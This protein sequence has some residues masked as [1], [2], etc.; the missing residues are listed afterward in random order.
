MKPSA[1][2]SAAIALASM[3]VAC[4]SAP[5][6]SPPPPKAAA[7]ATQPAL[8]AGHI[9]RRSV[10]H[11]LRQGPAWIFRRVMREEVLRDDGQLLGWRITGLPEEWSDVDLKPGDVVT[12]VNGIAIVMPDDAWNAWKTVASAKEIRIQLQ[13]A[14]ANRE[15]VIPIDGDPSPDVVKALQ[16]DQPPPRAPSNN[17]GTIVI[18]GDDGASRDNDGSY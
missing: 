4:S 7:P 18:E 15:L 5:P 12:K 8:P 9:A 10:E 2:L 14:G 6:P 11:V 17:R 16:S 1:K 13:R 3:A